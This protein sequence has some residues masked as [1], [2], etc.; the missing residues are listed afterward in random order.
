MLETKRSYGGKTS[1]IDAGE[2]S[3][4]DHRAIRIWYLVQEYALPGHKM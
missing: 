2:E 1:D 4:A 3:G